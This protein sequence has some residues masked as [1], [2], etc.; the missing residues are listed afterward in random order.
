MNYIFGAGLYMA[1]S[2]MRLH[3]GTIVGYNNEIVIAPIGQP[4]GEVTD[5]NRSLP[6]PDKANDTGEKG[7][8][9]PQPSASAAPPSVAQL[10]KIPYRAAGTPAI[11]ST[12]TQ[13]HDNEKTALVVGCVAIGLTALWLAR[14]Y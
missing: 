7:L 13:S 6:P 14:R 5:I 2:D 4:L 9:V 3:I 1:P 12:D 10:P 11:K 8:V